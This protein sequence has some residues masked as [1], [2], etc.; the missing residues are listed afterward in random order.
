MVNDDLSVV[1]GMKDWFGEEALLRERIVS[2]LKGIFL[3]YGFAPLETPSIENMSVLTKKGGGE[4]QEE[5]YRAQDQA[6]RDLG[7]RFDH[8][9]PLARFV[10]LKKGLKLPYK[11]YAIGEVFRDGPSQPEQGRYRS[12]LQCDVDTI[13]VKDVSAEAELLF[14]ANDAFSAIGLKGIEIR[15]NNRKILNGLL[16]GFGVKPELFNNVLVALD[17]L[18]KIGERQVIEELQGIEGL[19]NDEIFQIKNII[20]LKGSNKDILDALRGLAKNDEA[21]EGTEELQRILDYTS[22]LK[23]GIVKIAPYLARGL[24]YYTGPIMEVFAVSGNVKSSVLGGGRYDNMIGEFMGSKNKVYAVGFSFGL[25]RIITILQDE[26]RIEKKLSPAQ[27]FIVPL[28]TLKESFGITQ[29]LRK[30]GINVDMDLKGRNIKKSLSYAEALGI[31]YVGIIGEN[32]I[33]KGVISVKDLAKR[34]QKEMS[35][36]ELKKKLKE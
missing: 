13:G 8:T 19:G 21:K 31:P 34:S 30:A 36:E 12:F 10:A 32:E 14:L 35:I 29:K 9:V 11:R 2:T 28:N 5:I 24:D 33:K 26:K 4:I 7:L 15:L 20:E 25:E 22:S 16:R 1:K 3:R 17:K 27:I 23:K 6:G 18:D